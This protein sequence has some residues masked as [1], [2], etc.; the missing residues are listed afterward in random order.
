MTTSLSESLVIGPVVFC[1]AVAIAAIFYHFENGW[2]LSTCVFFA[3]QT[4][5][6]CNYSG[7]RES[8]SSRFFTLGLYM[9]GTTLV[10]GAVSVFAANIANNAQSRPGYGLEEVQKPASA[11]LSLS[12]LPLPL[13]AAAWLALG[14]AWGMWHEGFSLNHSLYVAVGAMSA[15]GD[16]EPQLQ[17]RPSDPSLSACNLG[18]ARAAFLLLY[19]CVGVNLYLLFM[20]QFA[21]LLCERAVRAQERAVMLRPLTQQELDFALSLSARPG[22][23]PG[24]GPSAGT[25]DEAGAAGA[26]WVADGLKAARQPQLE[27]PPS[28]PVRGAQAHAPDQAQTNPSHMTP[29]SPSPS[30]SPSASASPNASSPKPSGSSGSSSSATSLDLRDL[31]ILELLRLGRV[32]RAF[33]EEIRGVF[34]EMDEDGNGRLEAADIRA[35]HRKY[36][37][38]A[39]DALALAQAQAQ[40]QA[41]TQTQNETQKEAQA[42][43]QTQAQAQAQEQEQEQEE[44]LPMILTHS[45]SAAKR[46]RRQRTPASASATAAA[47]ANAATAPAFSFASAFVS[48]SASAPASPTAAAAMAAEASPVRRYLEGLG[49]GLGLNLGLGLGLGPN[50]PLPAASQD[51]GQNEYKDENEDKVKDKDP[52]LKKNE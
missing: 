20:S 32:D 30:P 8:E 47:A 38:A 46:D 6:G 42:Q 22:P 14:V 51:K 18:L 9:L 1:L 35:H 49:L 52:T 23:G 21:G 11:S 44:T 48:A 31:V 43:A 13:V 3:A 24:G 40:P 17:C 45:L 15:R 2:E 28:T 41:Q 26:A 25:A 7:P 19:C 34:L 29:T 36:Y 33:I 12:R 39:A 10:A 16:P 37:S 27:T 50:S 5:L 4:L